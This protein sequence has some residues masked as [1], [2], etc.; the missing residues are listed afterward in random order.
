MAERKKAFTEALKISAE[1]RP[2]IYLYH[3]RNFL[4]STA[5]VA[6]IAFYAD[7][8]PRLKTAGLTA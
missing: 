3:Q 8:L 7:G 2:I 6:G 4:V 5:D 1:E